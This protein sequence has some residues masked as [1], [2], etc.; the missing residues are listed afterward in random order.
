[1]NRF[2]WRAQKEN[3][4]VFV[5]VCDCDLCAISEITFVFA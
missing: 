5:F 1:M 4:N 2:Y 3:Q